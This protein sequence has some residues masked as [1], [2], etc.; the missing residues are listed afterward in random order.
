MSEMSEQELRDLPVTVDLVTA[1]RAFGLGRTKSTNWRA[2]GSSRA[3]SCGSARGTASARRTSCA[4]PGCRGR[5]DRQP[6]SP[7]SQSATARRMAPQNPAEQKRPSPS[8]STRP[9]ARTA[10]L[11][12]FT[13]GHGLPGL[14]GERLADD[15]G[16]LG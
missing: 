4:R 8:L 1:G 2:P 16:G 5:M 13:F 11:G 9:C 10:I 7:R 6:P 3:P 15:G 14:S 12:L